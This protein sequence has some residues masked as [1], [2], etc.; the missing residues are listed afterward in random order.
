MAWFS[1]SLRGAIAAVTG[2]FQRGGQ[3]AL[4]PGVVNFQLAYA[5]YQSSG[6]LAKVINIP[7]ADRVREW[8]DWQA[9]A[10]DI[11]AIEAEERRLGLKA[12]VQQAEVLRGIGGGAL[13]LAAPG[14]L[15]TPIG[16]IGRGGLAA[17]N[18]ASRWQMTLVHVDTN[19][20]SPTYGCP[21]LFRIQA[22]QGAQIDIHP[23][24]VVCFRGDPLPA[25]AGVSDEDRFWGS[26]RLMRVLR[27]VENSDSAVRWFAELVRKAKLTR[28]GVSGL[29]GY[30]RDQL[31][32]RV[33]LM[34]E[35]ENILNA[36]IYSLP[37]KDAAGGS[38][39]GEQI[40]DY[41]VT[42]TGIPQM[43]DAFDQRVA[44]VSDIPFTRLMGRS[45]AGMNATGSYD[46][47]NWAKAVSAGQQLETRP[48]LEQ[49]DPLL[50]ASAG[51]TSGDVT[52]KWAPLWAPT[53][54]EAAE[55]FKTEMEAITALQATA[56]IPGVAFTKGVQNWLS[57]REYIPGID[58]ALA[59]IPE[60][61]RFGLMPEDDGTDPSQTQ[62]GG[63]PSLEGARG[64]ET[65][66][67][68]RAAND[69]VTEE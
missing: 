46:D 20:A 47:Q 40:D 48:C 68:R 64:G 24:R 43:M 7:A 22:D 9:E 57:E 25:G 66:P 26:S 31:T 37:T 34:A 60:A 28:Y 19:L 62:G 50:L 21:R 45:P 33:A 16:A 42:W 39:G 30:D 53:E 4:M 54:K 5:A 29:D 13:I 8:R 11:E 1:D 6:L 14:D 36:T 55:T 35:A 38:S 65:A 58:A 3:I 17:V 52:W 51:V 69:K 59:E 32:K 49:M 15:A 27:E 63:D 56:T 41:Q 44:A 67:V 10:D 23:S 18:V 2:P 61:E 12:K